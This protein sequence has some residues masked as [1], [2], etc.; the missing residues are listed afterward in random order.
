MNGPLATDTQAY[1]GGGVRYVGR[2]YADFDIDYRTEHGHQ[3]KIDDYAVVDL[4]AGVEFRRFA[5][6]A[7]VRNLTNSHGLTTASLPVDAL[8]GEPAL[9]NGALSAGI[10]QPRTIGLTVG[11]QF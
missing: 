11:T 4:R 2:Q 7:F 5:V 10:I 9:P 6:E 1:V 3:R 8:F